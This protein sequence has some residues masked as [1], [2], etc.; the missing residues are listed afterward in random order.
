MSCS[1]A[2]GVGAVPL[3]RPSPRPPRVAGEAR[4]VLPAPQDGILRR[5]GGGS[6]PGEAGH[7]LGAAAPGAPAAAAR[8]PRA[9]TERFGPAGRDV[10]LQLFL[11]K[12][13]GSH[14]RHG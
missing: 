9:L 8:R 7:G 4:G 6:A 14:R 1:L 2:G 5:G 10:R 12:L 3:R 13:E 11:R